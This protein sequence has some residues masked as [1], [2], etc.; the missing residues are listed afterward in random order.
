MSWTMDRGSSGRNT[1]DFSASRKVL[2][3]R[4]AYS[5]KVTERYKSIPLY[6][7]EKFS[8]LNESC[9]PTRS[10]AQTHKRDHAESAGTEPIAS[11]LRLFYSD[12]VNEMLFDCIMRVQESF[13]GLGFSRVSD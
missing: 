3:S 1:D 5:S 8:L 7:R 13:T 2:K 10:W 11:S 9:S 6:S 12:A 4:M